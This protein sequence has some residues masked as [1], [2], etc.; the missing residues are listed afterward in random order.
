MSREIRRF[1]VLL[2]RTTIFEEFV[3]AASDHSAEELAWGQWESRDDPEPY[4]SDMRV[5]GVEEQED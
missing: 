3:F 2:R 4:D 1:R 5:V